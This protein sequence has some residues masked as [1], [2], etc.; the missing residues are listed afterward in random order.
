MWK[1]L[2][3]VSGVFNQTGTHS[4]QRR[5]LPNSKKMLFLM[6]FVYTVELN[7]QLFSLSKLHIIEPLK[8]CPEATTCLY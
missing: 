6:M 5:L 4:L 2:S 1:E 7:S 8:S 3:H